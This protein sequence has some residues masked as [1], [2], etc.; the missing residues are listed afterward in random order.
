MLSEDAISSRE[1]PK[2]KY[3]RKEPTDEAKP[4]LEPIA[5]NAEYDLMAFKR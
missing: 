4:D 1:K 3:Y 2:S 5:S